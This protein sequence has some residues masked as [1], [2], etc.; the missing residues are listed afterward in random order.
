MPHASDHGAV[1]GGFQPLGVVE[2]RGSLRAGLEASW[3][4]PFHVQFLLSKRRCNV[5]S[6]L[7]VPIPISSLLTAMFFPPCWIL[8][9]YFVTVI[10]K[11]DNDSEHFS[12]IASLK[13]LYISYWLRSRGWLNKYLL[14]EWI[15]G[16]LGEFHEIKKRKKHGMDMDSVSFPFLK[17]SVSVFT[18][19]HFHILPVFSWRL[20]AL[21]CK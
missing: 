3:P 9:R 6:Q 5:T 17:P 8:S 11:L 2:E 1:S 21:R 12:W 14:A 19:S 4:A 13:N 18:F 20:A 7:P 15:I 16:W 10:R